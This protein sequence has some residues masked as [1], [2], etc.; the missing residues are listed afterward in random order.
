MEVERLV[1]GAGVFICNECIHLCNSI[2]LEDT[3][4]ERDHIDTALVGD[5][6]TPKETQS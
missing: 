4:K 6:Q 3:G 5:L 2:L 1:A